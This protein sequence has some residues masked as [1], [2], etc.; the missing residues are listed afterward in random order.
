MSI[1]VTSLSKHFGAQKAV[2]DISFSMKKGEILGFLGPNGA[3][4]S[5][6]MKMLTCYIPPTS[7]T[8]LINGF[9]IVDQSLDVRKH[10]GYLPENNPLYKDMYVREYLGFIASL[11]KLKSLRS[12]V[13]DMIELTGLGLEQ[14]KQI[15]ALSKG[16]RQRVG[17][18][19]AMIHNPDILILDEPTSGL[20]PNQLADIRQLIK[21]FGKEKTVLFSSHIMQEVQALCDR[22][23]IIDKGKIVADDSIKHLDENV[24]SLQVVNVEF[25]K[26]VDKNLF[27]KIKG[28][29]E[30]KQGK[31]KREYELRFMKEND[32]REELFRLAVSLDNPLIELNTVHR[33]M[34]DVFHEFTG[35]DS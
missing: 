7:G 3:G 13:D 6:T 23:I 4:K 17:L 34:E 18:A 20:D 35:K 16:Y 8:A 15:G 21:Q 12:A 28:I 32:I 11:Y 9:D 1:A 22:V 10:V 27:S 14:H 31:S 5:T 2:D 25:V 30:I 19:Q 24:G 33:S 29:H 26:T